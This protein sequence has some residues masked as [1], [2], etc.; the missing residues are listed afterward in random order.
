LGE[1]EESLKQKD[2]EVQDL[3]DMIVAKDKLI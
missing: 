3:E 2:G 1:L